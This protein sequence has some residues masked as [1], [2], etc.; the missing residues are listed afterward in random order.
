MR[1]STLTK[2]LFF[3]PLLALGAEE[4]TVYQPKYKSTEELVNLGNSTFG[5][6]ASFSSLGGKVVINAS[7]KTTASVMKLFAELDRVSRQ[8][9]ISLRLVSRE[10]RAGNSISFK[11][12]QVSVGKKIS[13]GGTVAAEGEQTSSQA[14]SVQSAQLLEGAEAQMALGD[15]WFPGGFSA[16]AR[17]GAGDLVTVEFKQREADANPAFSLQ[18][19]VL[20]KLGEWKTVGEVI[21]A[22][23]GSEKGLANRGSHN[24]SDKK[25]LQ[26]KLELVK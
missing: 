2:L 12:G 26:V 16:K 19:E 13:A 24:G 20:L 11:N 14:Q 25:N 23:D 8:Y 6:K 3:I 4:F 7:P 22:T 10:E 5:G 9:K 21:R 15:S 17:G 1:L 18:N